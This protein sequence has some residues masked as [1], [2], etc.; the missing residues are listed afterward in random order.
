MV[1]EVYRLRGEARLSE[2]QDRSGRYC[3]MA[4]LG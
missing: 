1:L 3:G 4:S 2:I